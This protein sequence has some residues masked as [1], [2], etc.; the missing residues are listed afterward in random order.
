MRAAARSVLVVL[1]MAATWVAAPAGV[2]LVA[3]TQPHGD[4]AVASVSPAR[5]ETV[6]VAHPVVV[7]FRAPVADRHAAER[8][9]EVKSAPSMTG[10]F[11]WLDNEVVQWGPDR[12]WQGAP[13]TPACV[14]GAAG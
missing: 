4:L 13:P 7:T 12:Y 9:V 5:G 11:E 6:G 8:A 10:K 1:G 2:R 3:A 14:G